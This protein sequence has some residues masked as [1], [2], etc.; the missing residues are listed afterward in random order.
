M[1]DEK[2]IRAQKYIGQV[3]QTNN[4]FHRIRLTSKAIETLNGFIAEEIHANHR[5]PKQNRLSWDRI[6]QAL[7]KSK[8]AVYARYGKVKANSQKVSN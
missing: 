4:A 5:G 8:S 7:C 2:L 3:G 1:S 6:G